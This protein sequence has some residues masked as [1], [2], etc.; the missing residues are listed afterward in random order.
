MT[1]QIHVYYQDPEIHV[2]ETQ[3]IGQCVS[4]GKPA[5]AVAHNLMRAAGGGEPADR[6]H[7]RLASGDQVQIES[8]FKNR[9]KTWMQLTRPIDNIESGGD[10][11]VQ[12]DPAHR[13]RRRKLHTAVHLALRAVQDVT[14]EMSVL[15]ADIDEDALSARVTAEVGERLTDQLVCS[16]DSQ[17]RSYVLR[18][19][20]ISVM[21]A[22]SIDDAEA[23]LGH[24]LRV[25]DRYA[26][27]GK[28][29]I[30][31]IDGIDANPCSGLHA[32]NSDIGP[33]V[34]TPLPSCRERVLDVE[35]TLSSA[36]TYWFGEG[37][38]SPKFVKA[39]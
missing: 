35:I 27:K 7:L 37:A 24:L 11:T 38:C 6:G 5:I 13:E 12:I 31:L 34:M 26:F 8:V 3:I 28:V 19:A 32:Q 17:M 4:N 1:Q 33:Y 25:S 29:R 16:V 39:P 18:A 36:W 20:P 15:T 10:V 9:G 22:K 30:L 2:V 21:K 14:G 23:Q